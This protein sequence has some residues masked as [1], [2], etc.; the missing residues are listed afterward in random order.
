MKITLEE[1]KKMMERSGGSLCLCSTQIV[2]RPDGVTVGGLLDL[3]GTPIKSLPK[4]L[5]AD[6]LLELSDTP[7]ESLPEGLTVAGWLDLSGTPIK[8]LPKGLTVGGR[9][10]LSGTQ[11]TDKAAARKM[12]KRLSNGD[13]VERRY[14]YADEIL[15]PIK[16]RKTIGGYTVYCG[17]IPHRNVVS[18][19]VHYAHCDRIRDGI[20]DLLFK[21]AEDRGAEQ[22]R[23]LGLDAVVTLEEAKTMYRVITGAC[24]QGTEAFVESLGDRRKDTYTIRECVELT[25]GQYNAERFAAFFEA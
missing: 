14:L 19:G 18:D 11:I 5:T 2:I 9:L 24:R 7:I 6:G 3:S 4:G 22:Y 13:Y 20:A 12:V 1:A 8:S 10:Y 15:I 16:G 17:K 25:R 23:G 21:A